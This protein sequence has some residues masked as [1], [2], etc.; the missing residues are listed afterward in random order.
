MSPET[1]ATVLMELCAAA[2]LLICAPP[3]IYLF[4]A[5]STRRDNLIGALSPQSIVLYY[6]RFVKTKKVKENEAVAVFKSDFHR[7]YGRWHYAPALLML[8]L[9][10]G[11]AAYAG[12]RT[13]QTWAKTAMGGA[14]L[15]DVVLASIAG[16]FVWIIADSMSR[17]RR[18]DVTVADVYGWSYRL[19]IAAPFGWA[20]TEALQPPLAVPTAF[21][22][23]VFPTQTLTTIARRVAATQLKIADD[24]VTGQ[25]ELESLPSVTKANAER[26]NDEGIKA[27]TQ[28]AYCDPVD[29][30]IRTN[31]DFTYVTDCI[32]QALLFLYVGD[33]V[34]TLSVCSLR[35]AQEVAN[36]LENLKSSDPAIRGAAT[37]TLQSAATE[38]KISADA[39]RSTLDQVG[40]DPFTEFLSAIWD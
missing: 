10:T 31:F 14:K 11:I 16:G 28:L 18:R 15:P 25:S 22:L 36:L 27:V 37:A 29:L 7:R 39:L 19:L 20:L 3:T 4:T 12:G 40:E 38:L 32:N 13:L 9:T 30:T 26:F 5:W 8:F 2:A 23:G 6:E 17:V 24:P 35:G 1:Y 34:K 33:A 21:L